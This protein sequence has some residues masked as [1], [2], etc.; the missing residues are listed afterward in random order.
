MSQPN[1]PTRKERTQQ[2]I[3]A[4]TSGLRNEITE[5]TKMVGSL[6]DELKLVT[7]TVVRVEGEYKQLMI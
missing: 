6:K 2:L 5:L 4:N 3:E 1:A 7:Q